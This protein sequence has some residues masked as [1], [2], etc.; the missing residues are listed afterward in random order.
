M[1]SPKYLPAKCTNPDCGIEFNS[2]NPV[3]VG[4]N[5]LV[6]NT[7]TNCPKCNGRA[8]LAD[9]VTDQDGKSFIKMNDFLSFIR[10]IN[11]AEKLEELKSKIEESTENVTPNQF[12]LELVNINSGFEKFIGFINTIP[13]EK[14]KDFQNFLIQLIGL[15][16]AYQ[17]LQVTLSNHRDVIELDKEK[18]EYQKKIDAQNYSLETEKFEYQKKLDT[19]K[20]EEQ[21]SNQKNLDSIESEI[22]QLKIELE[23]SINSNASDSKNDIK[24][25]NKGRKVKGFALYTRCPCGS[26]SRQGICHPYGFKP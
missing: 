15:F 7:S 26:G 6:Q 19:E 1:S 13:S 11:D 24:N 5:S 8:V 23:N 12:A 20:K 25:L 4:S 3:S 17:T 2:F 22:N 21:K 9:F 14:L 10:T 18:F 16:I